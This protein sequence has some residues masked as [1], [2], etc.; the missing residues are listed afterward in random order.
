MKCCMDQ[1]ARQKAHGKVVKRGAGRDGG[2]VKDRALCV[3][4]T[5]RQDQEGKTQNCRYDI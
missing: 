2:G 5:E 3:G 1:A 4:V